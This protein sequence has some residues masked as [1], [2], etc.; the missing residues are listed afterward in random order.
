MFGF[1]TVTQVGGTLTFSDGMIPAG[2]AS[3]ISFVV[4]IPDGLGNDGF[5]MRQT[6]VPEPG[7]RCAALAMLG[8]LSRRRGSN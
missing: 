6:A 4:A 5:V 8:M 1:A 3:S 2:A 7:L